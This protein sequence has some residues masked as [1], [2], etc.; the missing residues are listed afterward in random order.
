MLFWDQIKIIKALL[1]SFD[2]T[3]VNKIFK[4]CLLHALSAVRKAADLKDD[5][6]SISICVWGK[7]AILFICF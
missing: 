1:I 3:S 7:S 4:K 6:N 2:Q 5:L